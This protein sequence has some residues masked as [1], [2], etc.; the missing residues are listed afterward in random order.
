MSG[1]SGGGPELYNEIYEFAASAGAFEG[2]VFPRERVD[3][4]GLTN[5]VGNLVRQ[6]RALP[7]DVRESFQA[8]LDRTIGRAI[9]SLIPLVGEDHEHVRALRS[10]VSGSLPESPHDFEREKSEKARKFSP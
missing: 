8:S 10:L 9:R 2:Y 4:G 3:P 5:W 6:Y 7:E 1:A